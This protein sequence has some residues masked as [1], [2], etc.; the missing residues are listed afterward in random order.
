MLPGR[1]NRGQ[2]AWHL[3]APRA[4]R[5]GARGGQQVASV[6]RATRFLLSPWVHGVRLLVRPVFSIEDPWGVEV[7]LFPPPMILQASLLDAGPGSSQSQS[8]C[9]RC[10]HNLH[11][12][13]H[14]GKL[15]HPASLSTLDPFLQKVK[16]AF[17]TAHPGG[18]L[19]SPCAPAVGP[20]ARSPF[21]RMP[22]LF[23]PLLG[24]CCAFM[25]FCCPEEPS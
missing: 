25:S 23:T 11:L 6:A 7:T 14:M 18:V 24:W 8:P 17:S 15:R 5:G 2:D 12:P 3:K 4:L 16:A 10:P 21:P 19:S 13:P 1:G 20:P 9:C 22:G